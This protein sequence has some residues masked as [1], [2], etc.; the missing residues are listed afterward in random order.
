MRHKREVGTIASLKEER[1]TS[2]EAEHG[3]V[4]LGIKNTDRDLE[5]TSD[6]TKRVKPDLLAVDLTRLPVEEIRD[7]T[8]ERTEHDVQETKHGCPASCA[9][10]AERLEVL[11]VVSAE[12]GVDGKL[13]AERAEITCDDNGGLRADDDTYGF[14]EGGLNDDFS[15]GGGEHFLLARD[16]FMVE[17]AMLG[18]RDVGFLVQALLIRRAGGVGTGCLVGDRTRDIDDV[19]VDTMC[20]EVML[21]G[22]VTL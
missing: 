16:G 22:E 5:S 6:D 11:Q 10:L 14:V 17:G 21:D 8:T 19:G 3:G 9:G 18:A 20:L 13:S 1:H 4:G 2:H 7:H 15:H 12:D